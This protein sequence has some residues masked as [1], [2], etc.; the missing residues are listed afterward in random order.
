MKQI[1]TLTA[2]PKQSHSL[3]LDNN[4]TADFYLEYCGRMESWYFSI[5]YNNTVQKCIKVVLTPNALRH[6]RRIIPFGIAFV[7]ESQVEPFRI[8]DF[9]T[10]RIKMYVLNEEDVATVEAEIYNIE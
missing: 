5:A 1:T 4:D 6:L 9:I 3:V 2:A 10:G 7:S 8:D